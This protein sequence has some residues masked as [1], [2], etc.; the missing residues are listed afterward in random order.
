MKWL[1]CEDDYLSAH[2]SIMP[3]SQIVKTT[4]R[5]HNAIRTRANRLGLGASHALRKRS[6]GMRSYT[7]WTSER[8]ALLAD[9]YGHISDQT[10]AAQLGCTVSAMVSRTAVLGIRKANAWRVK[11]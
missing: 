4:G 7:L 1:P 5:T 10:L 9:S 8:D 2:W 6:N 3:L 11:Q